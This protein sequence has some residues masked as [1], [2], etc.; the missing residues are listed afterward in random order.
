MNIKFQIKE[1][2]VELL[3]NLNLPQDWD[4]EKK[5]DG[6]FVEFELNDKEFY[7]S[8]QGRI[9]ISGDAERFNFKKPNHVVSGFRSMEITTAWS[10]FYYKF[11]EIH[12]Q[13]YCEY[14]GAWNGFNKQNLL[15]N[16]TVI[17][18]SEECRSSLT[19][20]IMKFADV[21]E[22]RKSFEKMKAEIA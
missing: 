11:Y 9:W 15:P 22:M 5:A 14:D 1:T 4:F 2:L 8:A 18:G 16:F 17:E 13:V 19:S 3:S 21:K 10:G 20:K 12:G 7:S 6:E